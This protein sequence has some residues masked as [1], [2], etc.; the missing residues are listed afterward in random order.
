MKS[1]R[2]TQD[3]DYWNR[4]GAN[5]GEEIFDAYQEDREGK[6]KRYLRKHARK[7]RFAIDIGC[8]TGKAFP[9]LSS[10]FG[11]VHGVDISSEL[12][13]IAEEAPFSNVT[14]RQADLSVPQDLP[15]SDFA[16]CCNVAILPDM[17][18]N[19]GIIRN[20]ASS[21]KKSAGAVFVLPSLESGLYSGWRL[22]RWFEK[23]GTS[24]DEIPKSD[25]EFFEDGTKS[26]LNGYMKISGVPT[27][28][29]LETE[30][31]VV[32]EEAGLRVTTIDKL[33]YNWDTE[34]SDPPTWMGPPFPWD[35]IVECEKR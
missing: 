35:W 24:F 20:V 3:K 32:F 17:E 26:L 5:Y 7:D 19:L 12:L 23:E 9:Y 27:K 2:E 25:L 8:G 29:Y 1:R 30:I 34:F 22:V 18:K 21:L 14:L 31:R 13:K 28:H 33:E 10:M 15:S 16:F 6:L 11:Q 4:I